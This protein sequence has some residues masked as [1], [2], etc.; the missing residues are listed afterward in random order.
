MPSFGWWI[1][2]AL[3]SAVYWLAAAYLI[4]PM[5]FGDRIGADGAI[6][7]GP[8]AWVGWAAIIA[9]VLVYAALSH[10]WNRALKRRRAGD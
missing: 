6:A 2:K 7:Y 5:L 9:A 4:A 8:P 10:A 1:A 3:L